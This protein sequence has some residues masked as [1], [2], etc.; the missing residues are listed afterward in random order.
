M[1]TYWGITEMPFT[2]WPRPI[3]APRC[4]NPTKGPLLYRMHACLPFYTAG[5]NLYVTSLALNSK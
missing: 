1:C 3:G 5:D 2:D 4:A